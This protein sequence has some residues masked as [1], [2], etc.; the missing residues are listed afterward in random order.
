MRTFFMSAILLLSLFVAGASA[1]QDEPRRFLDPN[2][3]PTTGRE[4]REFVPRGWKVET[5]EGVVTGD[6]NKD[7]SPDAVLRLVEDMPVENSEGVLNTR[8]RALV[9]LLAQPGGGYRRAAVAAKLLS[10]TTCSGVLGDPEGG[11][12]QI[13]I[14]NGVLNVNQLSG[15][16]EAT[17]LTQRFRYDAASGRFQLIGEDVSEYDRAAGGGTSTSTNYLTGLRVVKT[18]KPLRGG[19]ESNTTKTT[20][21][22]VK[23]RFI[24][25]VDYEQGW[26]ER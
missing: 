17:D 4:P 20:R 3:V 26:D 9:V 16:R 21:V 11:N 7:G 6:L 15:S 10:C 2:L 19:R 22:P 24:E 5:D 25:D 12:V 1:R 18:S 8:Y 14:K 23:S 13:E